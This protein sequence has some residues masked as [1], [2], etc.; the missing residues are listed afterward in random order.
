MRRAIRTAAILVALATVTGCG[1]Q[2]EVSGTVKYN[3]QL[4][5]KGTVTFQGRD[6]KTYASPIGSDGRYAIKGIPTGPAKIGVVVSDEDALVQHFKDKAAGIRNQQDEGKVPK[7]QPQG[8]G[9][10]IKSYYV[11]PP[12]YGDVNASGLSFDVKSGSQ[13]YDI[14]IK[15]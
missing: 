8:K 4:M 9:S 11:V 5:N 2:G 7:V 6:G 15:E 3:G 13:T 12:K 14:D 10:D 1:S